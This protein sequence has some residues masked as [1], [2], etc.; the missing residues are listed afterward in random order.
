VNHRIA[1]SGAMNLGISAVFLDG[2]NC[3]LDPFLNI[4]RMSRIAGNGGG[5]D[6][7]PQQD[8]YSSRWE[9]AKEKSWSRFSSVG[10]LRPP[11]RKHRELIGCVYLR[12]CQ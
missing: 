1:L 2:F 8:S 6:K 9:L 7:F 4:G 10:I 3:E 5:F 12:A 11:N